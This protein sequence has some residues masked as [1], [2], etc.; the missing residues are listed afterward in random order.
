VSKADLQPGDILVFN[1]AGHVGIYVGHGQLID[2]LHTGLPIEL[3]PFSG[4][5]QQVY[6]GAVRP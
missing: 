6:D 3:V 2:A 4:W 5:Y 1:G